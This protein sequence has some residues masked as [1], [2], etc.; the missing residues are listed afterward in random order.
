[1]SEVIVLTPSGPGAIAVVRVESPD[2]IDRPPALF[3]AASG[4][5]LMEQPVGRVAFGRWGTGVVEEVVACRISEHVAEIHCHGGAAAVARIVS[6]LMARGCCLRTSTRMDELRHTDAGTEAERIEQE[7]LVAFTQATSLRTADILWQQCEGRLAKEMTALST[8]P[9]TDARERAA[10]LLRW[11]EF[12]RHLTQPWKVVLFGRPNVGKSSLINALVGFSRS[13]VFDQ[14]GTTRDLVT[15]ATAFDGWPVELCDTAGLREGTDELEQAGINRAQARLREADL[16]VLVLDASLPLQ[17][18]DRELLNDWPDA[19]VVA[20]KAD[21]P[22]AS[23]AALPCESIAVSSL[24]G[25]GL[26]ELICALG[27]RLVPVAP[28]PL[29]PIPVHQR[30][31]SFLIRVLSST[32]VAAE[33]DLTPP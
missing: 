16:R 11:A 2:V 25:Q 20:H 18:Q 33:D 26:R 22:R 10:S 14:P 30:Q 8:L 27:S 32:S 13:I 15:A 29:T 19:V 23:D 28:P 9:P 31:V 21:L 12:G 24:T 4:F 17:A 5:P 1:M 7:C 6:D 3:V